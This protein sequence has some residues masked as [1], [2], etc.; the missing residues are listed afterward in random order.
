MQVG[1]KKTGP[2]LHSSYQLVPYKKISTYLENSKIMRP[3]GPAASVFAGAVDSGR[4]YVCFWNQL[5][6]KAP[7][8]LVA[9]R[10]AHATEQQHDE[11]IGER[12]WTQRRR[13]QS[14]K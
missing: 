12:C 2:G 5:R 10:K 7:N 1:G 4:A 3:I 11:A 8:Q 9:I 6:S 13:S 14:G